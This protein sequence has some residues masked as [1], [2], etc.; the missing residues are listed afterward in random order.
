MQRETLG[1][2]QGMARAFD[3]FADN[4]SG[5]ANFLESADRD[6]SRLLPFRRCS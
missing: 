2:F 4:M 1:A 6:L 5:A 3:G